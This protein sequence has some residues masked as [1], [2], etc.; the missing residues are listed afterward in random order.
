MLDKDRHLS[1]SNTVRQGWD[2]QCE[3]SFSLWRS[4]IPMTLFPL[5]RNTKGKL[6][7]IWEKQ[8]APVPCITPKKKSWFKNQIFLFIRIFKWEMSLKNS[9]VIIFL[10]AFKNEIW[11]LNIRDNKRTFYFLIQVPKPG[12]QWQSVA[13]FPY[14]P[15]HKSVVVI[16][17]FH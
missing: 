5:F 6:I 1:Q 17:W 12:A 3:G 10:L 8:I 16:C 14:V 7:N 13:Q 9:W 2:N 4:F 15:A 11:W